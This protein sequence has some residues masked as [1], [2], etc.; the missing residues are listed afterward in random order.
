MPQPK[1]LIWP[2]QLGSEFDQAIEYIRKSSIGTPK[3]IRI[4]LSV[5]HTDLELNITGNFFYVL[6][7]N[8]IGDMFDVRFNENREPAI[9]MVRMMGFYTPY[10]R[11]YITNTAQANGYAIIVY[12]TLSRPFLDIIDNRSQADLASLL[13]DIREKLNEGLPLSSDTRIEESGLANNATTILHTVTAGKVFHLC[14]WSMSSMATAASEAELKVR[15][16]LD[17]AQYKL[18][19]QIY[20]GAGQQDEAVGYT[21]AIRIPAGYDI[22]VFSDNVNNHARGFIYGWED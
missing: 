5:A 22:V 3:T 15:N 20:Q 2:S 8:A 11:F 4:D 18:N 12:G 9:T 6:E 16:E 14:G 19:T 21:N 1:K 13:E 10:Y 7:T 17:V